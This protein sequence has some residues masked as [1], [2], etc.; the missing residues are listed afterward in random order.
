MANLYYRLRISIWDNIATKFSSNSRS[1]L[2]GHWLKL[3]WSFFSFLL[4]L[5]IWNEKCK[6][7]DWLIEIDLPNSFSSNIKFLFIRS[8]FDVQTLT[9]YLSCFRDWLS[10]RKKISKCWL[11]SMKFYWKMKQL[12]FESNL[13]IVN[14]IRIYTMIV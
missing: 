7:L 3:I 9:I 2:K 11:F 6:K 1:H 8:D 5:T 14:T 12:V 4:V 13:N 10:F